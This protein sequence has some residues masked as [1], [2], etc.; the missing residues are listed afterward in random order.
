[1]CFCACGR[2]SIYIVQFLKHNCQIEIL[3]FSSDLPKFN[4]IF[5]TYQYILSS[6][7]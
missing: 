1:M 7:V 6:L 5:C 4:R 3:C 2:L